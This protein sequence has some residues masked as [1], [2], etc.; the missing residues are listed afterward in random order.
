[1]QAAPATPA[2]GPAQR[3]RLFDAAA[4]TVG[5]VIGA[6]I[7]R[8]PSVVAA[9][10][11]SELALA[12]LWA[13]GGLLSITGA[14]CYGE[15]VCAFPNRGGEYHFLARAFGPR[16][17]FVFGWARLAV[18]TTGSIAILAFIFADYASALVPLGPGE[19]AVYAG[20]VV[21]ALTALNALGLRFG[22]W[23]QNAFTVTV[24]LGLVAL[25]VAGLVRDAPQA[26]AS[27]APRT[28][29]IGLAM[30][31][32]LLTFGGWN[33]AAYLSAEV[34]GGER[35]MAAAV[36]GG[37]AAVTAIY[38]LVNLAYA[39]V[40][41]LEGLRESS[42]VGA[43]M[44]RALTGPVGAHLASALIAAA[45]LTSMNATIVT[46]S[47]VGFALGRDFRVFRPLG[48]WNSRAG[49]P[50][51]ALVAQGAIVV[52]LIALGAVSRRGFETM[53][54]YTAPV[55]WAFFFLTGLAVFVLR[56]T[57]PHAPRPFRVPLYPLTP[58]VFCASSGWLLYASLVHTRI[59]AVVGVIVLAL[60]T[61]P[62]WIE[63][64]R[65]RH[66]TQEES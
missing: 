27:A 42:T 48:G 45:A 34:R 33:E 39:R 10:A 4:M 31:F 15:L 54:E 6:G 12:G 1:M 9:G 43:D 14:L 36:V 35:T 25:A 52:G 22:T 58:L 41:G 56:L 50:V 61:I 23:L 51:A 26:A 63:T 59:G 53:V 17:A 57:E 30:V 21:I 55:F 18:I 40:L 47:R 64:T 5:I 7:F 46:G 44:M 32:V 2:G 13:L 11:G 16:P 3:L 65:G 19:N 24:V 62:L 20:A 60:G 29:S 37:V 28:S 8:A 38:L 66:R 49:A